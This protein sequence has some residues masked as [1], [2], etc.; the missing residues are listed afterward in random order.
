[1]PRLEP[2]G[3]H[4]GVKW[5]PDGHLQLFTTQTFLAEPLGKE[6]LFMTGQISPFHDVRFPSGVNGM[7]AKAPGNRLMLNNKKL[8]NSRE[9]K[10]ATEKK[11]YFKVII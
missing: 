7:V 1:L 2:G 11:I 3:G 9:R 8:T 5:I 4:D 6:G 10:V